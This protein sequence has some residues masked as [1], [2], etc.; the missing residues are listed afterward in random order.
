MFLLKPHMR[1][2]LTGFLRRNDGTATVEAVLWLPIFMIVF[3]LMIDASMIYHGQSK[4]LRVLQDANRNMSIGRFDS[5]TEIEAYINSELARFGVTPTST[6]A[7]TDGNVVLTFVTVPAAHLQALGYF[8]SLVNLQ[9]SVSSAHILDSADP[10]VFD[11]SI[12]VPTS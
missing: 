10:A 9:I 3:G 1:R 11:S 4:V 2:S 7:I 8:S 5:D 6:D 12:A